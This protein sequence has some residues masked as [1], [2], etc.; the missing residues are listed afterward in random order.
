MV[1]GNLVPPDPADH[2]PK[3]DLHCPE[4]RRAEKSCQ[5]Q[6]LCTPFKLHCAE[7]KTLTGEKSLPYLLK[8][9]PMLENGKEKNKICAYR[10]TLDCHINTG[11][12]NPE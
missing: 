2:E 7:P 4:K 12:V 9:K 10:G 5:K 6:A 1:L 8:E 3:S 11:S